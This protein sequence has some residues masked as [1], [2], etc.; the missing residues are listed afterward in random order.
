MNWKRMLLGVGIVLLVGGGIYIAYTQFF[1]PEPEVETA[2]VGEEADSNSSAASTS[3]GV[4]SAE[5]NIVPLRDAQLSFQTGGEVVEV[6]AEKGAV[7]KSGDPIIRLDATDQ[8]IGLVQAQAAV[9]IAEAG[10]QTAE[11]GLLAAQT[12]EQA[13]EVGLQAAQVALAL[14]MAEPTEAEILLS[15]SG[16]ALAQAGVGQ[17]AAGQGVVLQ[18]VSSSQ[19]QAAEA[20]LRAAEAQ[21]LPVRDALDALVREESNDEDAVA[22]AQLNYNAAVANVNAAQAAVEEARSGATSGQRTSAYGNVTAAA[23]QRDAAQAQLEQLLA[24][25]REEAITV[26]EASVAQAESAV[27]EAALAVV[28]AETAVTQ[29]DAGIAQAEAA[30]DS[31]QDA[32]TRMTLSAPFDGVVADIEPALGEVVGSGVPV[33]TYGDFGGWLVKTSDLT[34]L[35]VVDLKIGDPV[36]IQIDAIPGEV[37]IGTVSNIATTSQLTRGDVTYEVTIALDDLKGL[38]LRW[39]MTVFVDVDVE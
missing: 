1:A 38:P 20:Q 9:E 39:G 2:A 33:V 24:G 11:A 22:R 36:E 34:E 4:V 6:I 5:G 14:V 18:G 30:V 32:L 3:L 37:L 23:A 21:L 35:D 26:A 12:G 15:E 13:A 17:A 10:K 28:Q 19:I 8:E 25:S 27:A 16:V 29:A 7:V 31:A